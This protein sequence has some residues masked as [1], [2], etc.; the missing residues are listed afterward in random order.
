MTHVMARGGQ[1]INVQADGGSS[2]VEILT[3]RHQTRKRDDIV[4]VTTTTT[5]THKLAM[6]P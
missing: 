5:A 2:G 3:F 6:T 4:P 1:N